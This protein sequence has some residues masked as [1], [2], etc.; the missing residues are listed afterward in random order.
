[1]TAVD[2]AEEPVIRRGGAARAAQIFHCLQIDLRI[3]TT[4]AFPFAAIF[5]IDDYAVNTGR[6]TISNRRRIDRK[7][8]PLEVRHVLIPTAASDDPQCHFIN[9]PMATSA[10]LMTV[11]NALIQA[12]GMSSLSR[13]AGLLRPA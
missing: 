3:E 4:L 5:P 12:G 1:M 7:E 11:N 8:K 13:I 6:A 2:A 10:L 9:R